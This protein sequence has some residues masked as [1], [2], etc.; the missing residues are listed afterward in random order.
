MRRRWGK[1]LAIRWKWNPPVKNKGFRAARRWTPRVQ[2]SVPRSS[3]FVARKRRRPLRTASYSPQP[4]GWVARPRRRMKRRHFWLI[5]LLLFLLATI[6][7]VY[8]LDKYLRDPLMFMAKVRITQ[9]ATEAINQAIMDDVAGDADSSKMIQWKTN[10]DGK[11][12]GFFMDYKEQ[13]RVT[14]QTI[15]VV[16]RTLNEQSEQYERIPIG[17]AINSPIISSLGPS[18]AVRFHPASAVQVEVRTKQTSVGINNVQIEVYAHI[19]TEIAVLI[20]FDREPSSLETDIPL[21]YLMV[22]GDVPTY[23]YDGRGNPVGSGASQAPA[24]SLPNS[25]PTDANPTDEPTTSGTKDH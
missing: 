1:P 11:I 9:I 25:V 6:Q 22:V 24:L 16:E 5:M 14:A 12:T 8:W 4:Q 3:G 23:Y 10:D 21:S 13:M 19:K 2:A 17:H 15:Q 18:V 7:S 20:P